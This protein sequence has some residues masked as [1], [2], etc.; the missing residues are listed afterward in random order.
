MITL[1]LLSLAGVV[2]LHK[3]WQYITQLKPIRIILKLI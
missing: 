2:D 1:A 3:I